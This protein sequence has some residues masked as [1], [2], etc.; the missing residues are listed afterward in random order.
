[1]AS[2]SVKGT[3]PAGEW[4]DWL[5]PV[6]AWARVCAAWDPRTLGAE[7]V[8]LEQ[9]CGRVLDGDARAPADSPAF[10]RSAVDGYAV[11][12]SDTTGA[13]GDRPGRM[14][15]VGEVPMGAIS[16][17]TVGPGEAAWVATGSMIPP[18][19]DSVVMVE[20]TTSDGSVVAIAQAARPDDNIVRRGDDLRSGD[21]VLQAGRRPR[22][23]DIAALASMGFAR[24]GVRRRPRAAIIS[25]GDELAAPG[26][27]LAPGQVY[28]SNSYTMAAQ[29]AAWGGE[30][31]ILARVRDRPD[32]VRTAVERS[33][34]GAD[35]VFLS[36][37]SSVGI[38]DLTATAIDE[39]AGRRGGPGVIVHGVAMRPARPTII[40]VVAG[41]L[42]IGIPGNPVSAMIACEA[43]GRPAAEMLL[44][45]QPPRVAGTM[46][47]YGV[48]ARL[49]ERV[50]SQAGRQDYVRV[51]VEHAADGPLALPVRGGSHAIRSMVEADGLLVVPPERSELE[52]GDIV[53]VRLF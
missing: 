43:F 7:E 22:P 18:G 40:G 34:A 24:I 11:R 52:A 28:D 15:V 2:R 29:V 21:L 4:G 8:A 39:A 1:M 47:D 50:R 16:P 5:P 27:P 44:G 19:A 9:A 49:A 17:V 38:K 23:Q 51:R 53:E 48:T 36:G 45:M 33:V 25:G 32:E 6:T 35:L 14:T 10:D 41:V 30:P 31:H 26:Q 42:V 3:T 13:T 46:G 37:G 12:A 20:R